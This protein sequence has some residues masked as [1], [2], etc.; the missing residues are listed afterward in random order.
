MLK[1]WLDGIDGKEVARTESWQYAYGKTCEDGNV[2]VYRRRVTE[3]GTYGG[4]RWEC[5]TPDRIPQ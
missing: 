5:D 2:A 4:W 3:V 1:L